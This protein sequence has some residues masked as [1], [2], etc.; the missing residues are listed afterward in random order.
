MK[1]KLKPQFVDVFDHFYD[2]SMMFKDT[3]THCVNLAYE[4]T[5]EA[6]DNYTSQNV[7]SIKSH[8]TDYK[9]WIGEQMDHKQI[10]Y[11]RIIDLEN[12][13]I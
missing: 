3:S 12:L 8:G 11:K 10:N 7:S 4:Y 9:S 1:S 6:I 5:A 2:D 13:C